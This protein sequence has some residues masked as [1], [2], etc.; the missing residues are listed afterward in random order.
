[1]API[2]V[3]GRPIMLSTKQRREKNPT[4]RKKRDVSYNSYQK[5]NQVHNPGKVIVMPPPGVAPNDV[6][7]IGYPGGGAHPSTDPYTAAMAPD[8]TKAI[9]VF[10]PFAEYKKNPTKCVIF[11]ELTDFEQDPIDYGDGPKENDLSS[12]GSSNHGHS[13]GNSYAAPSYGQTQGNQNSYGS[14]SYGQN[15]ETRPPMDRLVMDRARETR[16]PMDHPV[17]D[18]ARR[19]MTPTIHLIT[20]RHRE[21]ITPTDHLIMDR[22][23]GTRTPME[24]H[25]LGQ[26]EA[27]PSADHPILEVR[28]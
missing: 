26:G 11:S 24:H 4:N 5:P 19:T 8:G 3:D 15:Q 7:Q 10:P 6:P 12:Y 23:R 25:L 1:M 16:P 28:R 27:K 9:A 20:D 18:R 21:M 17:M 13:Q 14:S 22:D 2:S